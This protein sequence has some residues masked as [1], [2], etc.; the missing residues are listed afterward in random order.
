MQVFLGVRV[1][2]GSS[3]KLNTEAFQKG[4]L[5]WGGRKPLPPQRAESVHSCKSTLTWGG[6]S[7]CI[8]CSAQ[9]PYVSYFTITYVI[10][11]TTWLSAQW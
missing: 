1:I 5:T 10:K 4:G 3:L 7:K 8:V 6:R 2:L 9:S 11:N